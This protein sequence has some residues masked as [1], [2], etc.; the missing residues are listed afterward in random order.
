MRSHWRSIFCILV[1]FVASLSAA[2]GDQYDERFA[3][4]VFGNANLDDRIDESD[5]AYTQEVIAGRMPSNNL[6]DANYD[7][8]IDEDDIT[9]IEKIIRGEEEELTVVS[10]DNWHEYNVVTIKKPVKTVLTRFFD[11]AEVLRIFNSTDMIIAVGCKNFQENS[12]FFPELSHLP[13]VADTRASELDNEYIISM[14]PDIFLGWYKENRE[15]LPGINLIHSKLWGLNSSRDI[16][17]LGYILDKEKEAEE[18]IKWHDDCINKIKEEVDKIPLDDRPRV[19][20]ALPQPGGAFGVY[21]GEGGT[22]G[23]DDLMTLIPVNSVGQ[24]LP[25]KNYEVVD[26]EWVIEQN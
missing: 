23:M 10:K 6:T 5:I 4:G 14:N 24:L 12:H 19:L 21:R 20:V 3:L 16:R 25:T 18:Y 1:S 13:Y 11:S 7:G 8:K 22:N 2:S 26:P 17:K 15:K 9:Q